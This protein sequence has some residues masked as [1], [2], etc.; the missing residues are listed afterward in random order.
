M[1]GHVLLK[2]DQPPKNQSRD[3]SSEVLSVYALPINSGLFF[4]QR[5]SG[6]D[7]PNPAI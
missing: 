1:E 6:Q 4:S 2:L 5:V 3:D 7:E